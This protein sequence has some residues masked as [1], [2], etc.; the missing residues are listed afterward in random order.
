M[1]SEKW[2]RQTLVRIQPIKLLNVKKFG[3]I[4][5]SQGII[6]VEMNRK[7]MKSLPLNG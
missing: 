4:V 7:K 3:I 1:Q 6:I 5:A 2:Q